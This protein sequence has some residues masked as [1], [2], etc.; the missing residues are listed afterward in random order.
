VSKTP[1]I[2][3]RVVSHTQLISVSPC[4]WQARSLHTS[5]FKEAGA[6]SPH[7]PVLHSRGARSDDA[8]GAVLHCVA[9]R[10]PHAGHVLSSNGDL[11]LAA[12]TLAPLRPQTV[13][14]VA[15]LRRRR[16]DVRLGTWH[17]L[18]WHDDRS[19]DRVF[20]TD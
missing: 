4:S 16:F 7:S 18:S 8:T 15:R 13:P 12:A 5:P 11:L 3:S 19:D 2:A 20:G 14:P 9:S 10:R 1:A 17:A 6:C